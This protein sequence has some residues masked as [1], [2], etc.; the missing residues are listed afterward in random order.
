MRSQGTAHASVNG[1][2]HASPKSALARAG[3]TSLTGLTTGL[4]VNNSAGTKIGTVSNIFA[5]RTG[6]VVGVQV[7]LN[8]GG[9]V[10]LPAT[11]L[12]MNGTTVVTSSASLH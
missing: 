6:A 8:G 2:V 1:L 10:T 3:V 12:S 5:N 4:A 9:S 11:S 7:S